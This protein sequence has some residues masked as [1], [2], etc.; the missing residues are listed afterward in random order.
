MNNLSNRILSTFCKNNRSSENLRLGMG[1]F[2]KSLRGNGASQIT[3]FDSWL[4]PEVLSVA[5]YPVILGILS[6]VL[7]IAQV[8]SAQVCAHPMVFMY[9]YYSCC[10]LC[11]NNCHKR[12]LIPHYMWM[13]EVFLTQWIRGL[14]FC[15]PLSSLCGIQVC[16]IYSHADC[17]CFKT[18][19]SS[20]PVRM[21]QV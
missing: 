19:I 4:F 11:V 12:S 10:L 16:Q 6:L 7:E 18:F 15:M 17:A 3:L 5:S 21:T 8:R 13:P 1:T 2:S 9:P 14:I 20:L